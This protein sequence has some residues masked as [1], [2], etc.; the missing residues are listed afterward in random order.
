M[1][2][3]TPTV[4]VIGGPNGAGKSTAARTV[5]AETLRLLTFVNA[6]VIAQGLSGFAPDSAA[7]EAGR[8]MQSRLHDLA[9]QRSDF[10]FET[11]LAGRSLSGWLRS[12]RETGYFVFL[13]YC[14]LDTPDLSVARVAHRV[15][16][17]GHDVPEETIR[18]RYQRSVENFFGLYRP[19][20]NNWRVYDN[21]GMAGHR[22]IAEGANETETVFE[23]TMWKRMLARRSI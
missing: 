7:V 15:R 22:L 21:S 4:V 16:T 13:I 17:G 3:V 14:W 5:L 9:R 11:T 19:I 2:E 20:A 10:A 8:I 18:R 23:E 12:L 1:A 6:D